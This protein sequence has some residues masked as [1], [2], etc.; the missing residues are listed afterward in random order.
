M[1]TTD[2]SM[3]GTEKNVLNKKPY[4][5]FEYESFQASATVASY[6]EFWHLNVILK[7]KIS[8]GPRLFGVYIIRYAK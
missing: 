8:C 5:L 6:P 4:L 7:A 1:R 3:C 2:I